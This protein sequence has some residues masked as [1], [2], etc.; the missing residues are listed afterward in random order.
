MKIK[1]R[2]KK[3]YLHA[4]KY[5]YFLCSEAMFFVF[6]VDIADKQ[7]YY[8]FIRRK[9]PKDKSFKKINLTRSS[10]TDLFVVDSRWFLGSYA[11]TFVNQYFPFRDNLTLWVKLI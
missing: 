5:P 6:G 3:G 2:E 4:E 9:N 8:L 10:V 1:L 7:E 11:A